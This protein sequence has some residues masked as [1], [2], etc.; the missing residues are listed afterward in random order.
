MSAL[1][2][3]SK[4]ERIWYQGV[5]K[6][7]ISLSKLG[8]TS[9]KGEADSGLNFDHM[10]KNSPEGK[11]LFGK[12]VDRLLLNLPSVKATRNRKEII[13]RIL[14]NEIENNLILKKKTRILDIAS[15]PARYLIELLDKNDQ[16]DIE[17]LCI[18]KDKRCLKFGKNLAGNKPIR[19]AKL[20]VFKTGHL[21]RLGKR[22]SWIPNIILSSGLFEYTDD[23]SV[24]RILKETHD[25]I[26]QDGL[27][28]FISQVD[29]PSKRLMSN[30]CTTSQGKRWE[31]I[32][33]KPE[34]FREWLLRIGFRN[35]IISVDKWGMYEFCTCRKYK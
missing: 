11:T 19:Y 1:K 33:R 18:D 31:L 24:K 9:I 5:L 17:V 20:D 4:L 30:V 13:V 10:Y 14:K 7:I 27:F 21:K 34:V 22:I 15:G 8:I 12:F 23:T 3:K 32:Y 6:R 35:V 2:M 29:N 16:K 28:I 26:D 25:N